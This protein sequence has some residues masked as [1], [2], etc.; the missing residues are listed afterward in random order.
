MF[1]LEVY[2]SLQ[3]SEWF[4]SWECLEIK[5][6]DRDRDTSHEDT[7]QGPGGLHNHQLWRAPCIVIILVK[8]KKTSW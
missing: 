3:H 1:F 4:A 8:C 6:L 2:S 7:P 5:T